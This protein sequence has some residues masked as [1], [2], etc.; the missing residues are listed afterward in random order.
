MEYELNSLG[1]PIGLEVEDWHAPEWPPHKVLEGR[2]CR[3]EPLSLER[4]TETLFDAY[5][6]DTEERLWTY[7]PYG[8]FAEVAEYRQWLQDNAMSEDPL[9]YAIVDPSSNAAIGVASYMRIMP[10]MGSVEIG[11]LCYSPLLQRTTAATEAIYIMMQQV[12]EQ[13]YR[14]CEWKCNALNQASRQAALRLGF[15]FEGIFRQALITKG[16]NRDTAWLSVIDGEWPALQQ[17]IETWLQPSNF[18]SRGEQLV[19]LSELT[20]LLSA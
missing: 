19:S 18:D 15:R 1:Q 5:R 9:F 14:R 10:A 4:H 17:A 16:R 7:L 3:L 13:G 8:P 6:L 11:H 20:Q 2:Y 12:F